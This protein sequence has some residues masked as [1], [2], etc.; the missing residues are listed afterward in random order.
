MSWITYSLVLSAYY[1]LHSLM[2]SMQ[3]KAAFSRIG[4]TDQNYRIL[5]NFVA[6]ATS[7]GVYMLYQMTTSTMDQFG[8]PVG[9]GLVII[10]IGLVV[11]ALINYDLMAFVGL[12]K[13]EKHDKLITNG[14]NRYIRHPL[15]L[16][17]II[18]LLGWN[19]IYISA[20]ALS[21]LIL[22]IIYVQIG[23]YLEEKKLIDRFGDQYTEYQ[24][25]VPKLIPIFWK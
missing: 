11:N 25:G 2:A 24:K 4:F 20:A 22:T 1:A 15:Y 19:T 14:L 10:G 21:T 7:L 6:L 5:F 8:S 23:I 13:E 16:G 3:V 9:G 12:K 18:T 17:I